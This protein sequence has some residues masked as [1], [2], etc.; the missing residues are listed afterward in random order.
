M[1]ITV[2]TPG[3]NRPNSGGEALFALR[4]PIDHADNLETPACEHKVRKL[5]KSG[6][7]IATRE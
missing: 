7:S 4:C 6:D 5:G 3:F 2:I 1:V